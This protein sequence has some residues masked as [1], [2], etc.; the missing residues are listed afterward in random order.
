[1]TL[2]WHIYQSNL[3]VQL[4]PCRVRRFGNDDDV[5]LGQVAK[6]DLTRGDTVPPGDPFHDFVVQ[7]RGDLPI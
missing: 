3:E 2:S 1:M 7:Q 6:K 4:N 5:L